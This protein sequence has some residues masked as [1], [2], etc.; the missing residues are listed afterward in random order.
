MYIVYTKLLLEY[1]DALDVSATHG[2][3]I[4]DNTNRS[5]YRSYHKF[6]RKGI[7]LWQPTTARYK[8]DSSRC[9]N[10]IYIVSLND[11]DHRKTYQCTKSVRM[12]IIGLD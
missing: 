9:S 1:D 12:L 2:I 11:Y 6:T 5:V 4:I 10:V 7:I 8:V 3:Y